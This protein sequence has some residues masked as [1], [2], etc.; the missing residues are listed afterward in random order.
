[1]IDTKKYFT[2]DMI[3]VDWLI[4]HRIFYSENAILSLIPILEV[5]PFEGKK[6]YRIKDL[7]RVIRQ[8]NGLEKLILDRE[9]DRD[10]PVATDT[11]DDLR[12]KF[13]KIVGLDALKLDRFLYELHK[14]GIYYSS[15]CEQLIYV[16]ELKPSEED[17][18]VVFASLSEKNIKKAIK[19][20]RNY[21][22]KKVTY[23]KRIVSRQE[24]KELLINSYEL[25]MDDIY[26]SEQEKN[27]GSYGNVYDLIEG[28]IKDENLF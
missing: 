3:C 20:L 13:K 4:E 24:A 10:M 1:M 9:I 6:C 22:G 23:Q 2:K 11:I 26:P 27:Y 8:T 18:E 5:V 12:A 7:V 21:D 19:N 17:D 15:L 16:A 28:K 14:M 25:M